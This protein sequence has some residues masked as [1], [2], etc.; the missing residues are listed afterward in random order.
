MRTTS[1]AAAGV[2]SGDKA[3]MA[4]HKTLDCCYVYGTVVMLFFFF[5]LLPLCHIYPTVPTRQNNCAKA[6]KNGN[7]PERFSVV[8]A[9]I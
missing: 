8:S 9:K 5:S 4:A 2:E 3:K 7:D 6:K 1:A